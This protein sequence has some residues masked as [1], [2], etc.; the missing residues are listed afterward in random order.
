MGKQPRKRPRSSDPVLVSCII[1]RDNR[2]VLIC[3][4]TPRDEAERNWEFP[5]GPKKRNETPE[6]AVRRVVRERVA[7][8][9]DLHTGQPPFK[10]EYRGQPAVYRFFLAGLV[11]GEAEP[12]G[13]V[14]V[15]WVQ[16]GQLCEYDF[17]PVFQS[18]VDWYTEA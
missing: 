4:E 3:S 13:Y 14:Q 5:T 6:D 8:A 2:E 16:P 7:L 1:E 18:V 11:S 9:I 12:A 15:R 10:D 17:G